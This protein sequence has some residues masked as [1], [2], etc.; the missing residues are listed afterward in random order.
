MPSRVI[1]YALGGLML[2]GG[3][4]VAGGIATRT[5]TPGHAAF[6]SYIANLGIAEDDI[7]CPVA[8]D[9]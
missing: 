2:C 1:H 6:L 9:G 7:D 4:T 5:V 8:S 3:R